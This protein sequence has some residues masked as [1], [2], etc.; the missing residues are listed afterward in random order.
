MVQN[1]AETKKMP[2]P[3]PPK[4]KET[5]T[6]NKVPTSANIANKEKEELAQIALK[7]IVRDMVTG[8]RSLNT[9]TRTLLQYNYYKNI[10]TDTEALVDLRSKI[11]SCFT[12]VLKE[13]GQDD[14]SL[15][16]KI[17]DFIESSDGEFQFRELCDMLGIHSDRVEKNKASAILGRLVKKDIIQRCGKKNGI[18][19]KIDKD[20]LEMDFINAQEN[21][22]EIWL[23]FGL[24][25][26]IKIFP[27][28]IIA[29]FGEPN[30][31]KSALCFNLIRYNMEKLNTFYFNSEMGGSEL[32]E[33]LKNF[34]DLTLSDW[35][36][37]A[38]ER[39]IDFA[40]CIVPGE[41]NLNIIDYLEI[42]EEHWK[43]G[44][45][46]ND[47]HRKLDGAIA[48]ICIQKDV[49]KDVGRGGMTTIEKPR[50]ALALSPGHM[51]IVKAKNWKGT[52]N[53]NGKV[54]Q[55]KLFAGCN[56]S[57]V[58]DWYIPGKKEK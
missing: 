47:I 22:C 31:G 40:D 51:K 23:P 43:I 28:N 13:R 2:P 15:A 14:T 38:F 53:P 1:R 54:T 58:N 7:Q 41:G 52:V 4:E 16:D 44:S 6:A 45:L 32:K 55:Y 56:I 26:M 11:L 24:S 36:F 50:L 33:R 37:R 39:S 19:R 35:K 8:G 46:I 49:G 10:K 29:I 18:F 30:T 57:Q 25:K 21:E 5:P 9:I 17:L 34:N 12:D 42:T 27:G 20:V 3:L 48:I